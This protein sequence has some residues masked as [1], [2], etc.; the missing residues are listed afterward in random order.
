MIFGATNR[1]TARNAA[2]LSMVPGNRRLPL[3][4]EHGTRRVRLLCDG[5]CMTH[6]SANDMDSP[7]R[8]ESV[9]ESG[10]DLEIRCLSRDR[11]VWESVDCLVDEAQCGWR[12]LTINFSSPQIA[13]TK[14]FGLFT[15]ESIGG[16]AG[17][18]LLLK[19]TDLAAPARPITMTIVARRRDQV[20]RGQILLVPE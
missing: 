4:Y 8:V 13:R 18:S 6:Y 20:I 5:A 14:L 17:L 15:R 3:C 19:P 12:L 9:T 16:R 2:L 11:A 10:D 7:F 1:V